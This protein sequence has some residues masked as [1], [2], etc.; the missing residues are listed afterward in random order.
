MRRDLDFATFTKPLPRG[1]FGNG[2]DWEKAELDGLLK[3]VDYLE[4]VSVKR[5]IRPGQEDFALSAKLPGMPDIIFSHAKHTTWNGCELCHPEIFKVRRGE[6]RT[7]MVQ[8]F[9][10]QSCGTCHVTVAFP[11]I[12]CQRCHASPVKGAAP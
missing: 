3:P 1:R 7:S 12:D 8:I 4:G 2:I 11:L 6:T 5:H 10:G 9:E